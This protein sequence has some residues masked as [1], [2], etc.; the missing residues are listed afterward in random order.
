M[1]GAAPWSREMVKAPGMGECVVGFV[2]VILQIYRPRD[3]VEDRSLE[4]N[5]S[6]TA[7][8]R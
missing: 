3:D 5:D 2:I 8:S 4:T 7:Y 1:R 6:S